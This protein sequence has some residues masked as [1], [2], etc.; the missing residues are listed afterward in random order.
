MELEDTLQQQVEESRFA[1]EAAALLS[2]MLTEEYLGQDE[3]KALNISGT[4]EPSDDI[5]V[6][7]ELIT[8]GEQ[9]LW[10][11]NPAGSPCR[12]YF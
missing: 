9:L 11:R 6:R 2:N 1:D 8:N 10:K 5:K 4:F 3:A 7:T 12:C